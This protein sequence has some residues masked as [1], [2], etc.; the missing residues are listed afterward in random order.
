[1]WMMCYKWQ[2]QPPVLTCLQ[3][4]WTSFDC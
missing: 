1:M 2:I 3:R 4:A